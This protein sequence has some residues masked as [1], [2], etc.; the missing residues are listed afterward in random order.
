VGGHDGLESI[1]AMMRDFFSK[2]P[3]VHWKVKAFTISQV[4]EEGACVFL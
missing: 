1:S 3:A 4:R 2:F